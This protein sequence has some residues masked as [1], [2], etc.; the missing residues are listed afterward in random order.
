MICVKLNVV[1][2]RG[3]YVIVIVD[4][5][6]MQSKLNDN[7]NT[8]NIIIMITISRYLYTRSIFLTL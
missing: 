2:F 6:I 8:Y 7:F 3:F 4:V 5:I 1:F